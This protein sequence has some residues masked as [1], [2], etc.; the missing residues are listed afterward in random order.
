MLDRV[1]PTDLADEWELD[2]DSVEAFASSATLN[3]ASVIYVSPREELL[4][5]ARSLVS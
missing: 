4:D 1:R 2:A 3:D 5:L